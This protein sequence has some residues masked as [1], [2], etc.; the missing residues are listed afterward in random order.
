MVAIREQRQMYV[1]DP[2]DH[3]IAWAINVYHCHDQLQWCLRQLR[4]H[5]PGS[6]VVIVNDGDDRPY[7]D[8]AAAY[9]C[10]CVEGSH[11]FALRSCD[12]YVNRILN[13]LHA[14]REA[15]CF[16]IDPDT[17]IWRRFRRL[18]ASSA[19]FGTVET[20]TEG[21]RDEILGAPNVQGGCIGMTRDVVDGI[22]ASGVINPLVCVATCHETWARCGDMKRCIA[23]GLFCDDFI[24]S[25]AAGE[26]GAPIVNMDEIRSRWRLPVSNGHE[27]FAVTHPHKDEWPGSPF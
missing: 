9:A 21:G 6:R 27:R 7:A 16:K 25:W 22:L 2:P 24:L 11:L 18:P 17:K 5:Y 10:E 12:R 20:I 8:V 14:G 19:M 1:V 23:S 26:I 4:A 13:A 15:Y 3:E